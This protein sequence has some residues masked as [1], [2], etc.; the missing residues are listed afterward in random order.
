MPVL[1]NSWPIPRRRLS[2]W[3]VPMRSSTRSP[4]IPALSSCSRKPIRS[5]ALFA[6]RF[7]GVPGNIAL[8]TLEYATG[9]AAA[10]AAALYY[11]AKTPGLKR[12][13]ATAQAKAAAVSPTSFQI[14][15]FDENGVITGYK[16]E[17]ITTEAA[18][19]AKAEAE[20]AAKQLAEESL[21]PAQMRRLNK[22]FARGLAGPAL[23]FLGYVLGNAGL[24]TGYASS[25]ERKERADEATNA[26]T[27]IPK[28]P[29]GS[30]YVNGRWHKI[31]WVPIFGPLLLLG[32]M[33]REHREEA[34]DSP[35]SFLLVGGMSLG[36]SVA[37]MPYVEASEN[38]ANAIKGESTRDVGKFAEDRLTMLVPTVAAQVAKATDTDA[39]GQRIDRTPYTTRE[40]L[41]VKIPGL[42]QNVTPRSAPSGQTP[43]DLLNPFGSV[44]GSPS[45][46]D[47]YADNFL[48]RKIAEMQT[49]AIMLDELTPAERTA[50][51]RA[52]ILRDVRSDLRG[53]PLAELR[54]LK[55]EAAA[56]V[57]AARAKVGSGTANGLRGLRP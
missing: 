1:R 56:A 24:L 19:A 2:C 54:G 31:G 27:P 6:P 48:R 50:E 41:A 21:T 55:K 29:E 7:T 11:A 44:T 34:M 26:E 42:R 46:P 37:D 33:L 18:K 20:A 40:A 30:I 9:A 53:L 49:E 45:S 38:F 10:P 13:A 39:Q 4:T 43:L 15:T 5:M 32:A 14:P 16:T 25:E 17:T 22:M 52:E 51:A 12:A 36:R 35:L 3:P 23:I 47:Q 8:R 57:Q 28:T